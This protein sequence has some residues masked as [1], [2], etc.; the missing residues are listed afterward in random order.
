MNKNILKS[1]GIMLNN[2]LFYCILT[3]F[4]FHLIKQSDRGG[5][6]HTPTYP[7]KLYLYA[8]TLV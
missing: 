4:H 7:L 8:I 1:F 3:I 6:F 2:K 5:G